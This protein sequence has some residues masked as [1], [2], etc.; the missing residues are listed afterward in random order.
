VRP[1][2]DESLAAVR[3]ALVEFV[4][5]EVTS[6]YGRTE[7][8]YALSLLSQISREGDGAVADMVDEN[9][10]LRKLL[11]EAGRRLVGTG[12]D[13][14]LVAELQSIELPVAR[15]DL[16]LSALREENARLMDVLIRLQASCESATVGGAAVTRVYRKTIRFLEERTESQGG[17]AR[18]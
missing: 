15:P 18:R 11:R 3:R 6:V 1:D 2:R 13:P 9:V 8:T 10:S 16:R 7:L 17:P 4:A 14:P 12:F 5:P